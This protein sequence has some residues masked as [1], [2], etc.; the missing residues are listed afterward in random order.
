MSYFARVCN[1]TILMT[2]SVAFALRF[3]QITKR[4]EEVQKQVRAKLDI[5]YIV[6]AY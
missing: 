1:D 4:I 3:R 2:L 6:I 5:L